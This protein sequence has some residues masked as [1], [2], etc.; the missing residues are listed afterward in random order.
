M[1]QLFS[2]WTYQNMKRNWEHHEAMWCPYRDTIRK[3]H[4]LYWYEYHSQSHLYTASKHC[5]EKGSCVR[6]KQWCIQQLT[7]GSN[8]PL[9]PMT[10]AALWV[11]S[12]TFNSST[13]QLKNA[14]TKPAPIPARPISPTKYTLGLSVAVLSHNWRILTKSKLPIYIV[15]LEHSTEIAI[16]SEQNG[17]TSELGSKNQRDIA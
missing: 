10:P 4:W 16:C 7:A 17:V 9:A 3:I 1:L 14:M 13:G 15:A 11:C 6:S 5:Y 8:W 12:L 2:W